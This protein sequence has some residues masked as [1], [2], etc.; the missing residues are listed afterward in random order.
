MA[1]KTQPK[2]KPIDK[3]TTSLLS[4]VLKSVDIYL[5]S[6]LLDKIIDAVELLEQKGENVSL[7][8]IAKLE[9]EWNCV[10]YTYPP[11]DSEIKFKFGLLEKIENWKSLLKEQSE[12]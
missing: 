11:D 7:K 12:K 9:S 3:V 2:Q 8:D 6:D 10:R 1:K 4:M 5:P